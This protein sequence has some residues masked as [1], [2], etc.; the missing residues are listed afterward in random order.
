MNNG[1]ISFAVF[2][3]I[4]AVFICLCNSYGQNMVPQLTLKSHWDQHSHLNNFATPYN[5]LWG[6][7]SNTGHEYAIL[8]SLDSIYFF[9]V[10][11]PAHIKRC[12]TRAGRYNN[13]VNREFKTYKNYCYAVSDNSPYCSLQ[14]FDMSYL[15]DSVHKVYDS[16]SLSSGAHSL[17]I[18]GTRLYLT[19]NKRAYGP[20]QNSDIPMTVLSIQKPDSPVFVADLVAPIGGNNSPEFNYVHDGFARNDTV[21]CCCGTSGMFIYNYKDSLNPVLLQIISNYTQAG[22]NHSCWLSPDGNMLLFSDENAYAKVKLYDVSD[23]KTTP[24]QPVLKPLCLFGSHDTLGSTAHYGYMKGKYIYMSY[25]ED[26]VVIFDMSDSQNVREVTS[27]DTYPQNASGLYHGLIGCWNNYPFFASGNI[28]AS[29]MQNGLFVLGIDSVSAINSNY[30]NGNQL[31]IKILNNPFHDQIRFTTNARLP[32]ELKIN[33][34]DVVGKKLVST[35]YSIPS[36]MSSH[37]I[38]CPFINNG[39]LVFSATTNS[40][41][42]T[43]KLIK[44]E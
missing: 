21:Y 31:D 3:F 22:Y 10:T 9:D 4:L 18:D 43:R 16:D 1:R 28:I 8:G 20:H 2:V 12:D 41:T 38:A 37:S 24:T 19:W 34:F 14:V 7:T 36:G 23:L 25:Y 42:Y 27:Y 29:D 26:G 44:T 32:Q 13:C 40:S 5:S 30:I 33:I 11:D 15:P 35:D 17:F 6:W 39:A